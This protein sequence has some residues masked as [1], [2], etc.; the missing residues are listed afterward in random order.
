M[1]ETPLTRDFSQQSEPSER[2]DGPAGMLQ[3]LLGVFVA[4]VRT[5]TSLIDAPSWFDGLAVSVTL[6]SVSTFAFASSDL[7]A[8]LAVERRVTL[9]EAV[10]RH[11]NA[12]QFATLIAREQHGAALTA[13]F[14]GAWLVV[15]TVFVAAGGRAIAHIAI[16]HASP[17]LGTLHAPQT[18]QAPQIP[19]APQTPQAPRPGPGQRPPL[20]FRHALSIAAHTALIMG[21]ATPCRLLLNVWAGSVGPATSV[22][23]LLPF[24]PADTIWAHLGNAIDLFGL[25][26][27]YTLATGFAIVYLRRPEGLRLVFIGLYL[28]TA[29]VQA[30]TKALVGAPSF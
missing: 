6:V 29:V 23:V 4:P 19:Q 13:A 15:F 17:A 21:L 24:L 20:R 8:R 7:G 27:A 16:V 22:G 26:W 30:A 9:A 2:L 18:A 14:A 1:S 12:D 10:G 11:V 25:W 5:F 28:L 3:R